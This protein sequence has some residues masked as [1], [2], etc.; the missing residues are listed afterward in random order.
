MA[1]KN[2]YNRANYPAKTIVCSCGKTA[3]FCSNKNYPFGKKSKAIISKFYR[4]LTCKKITFQ[5]KEE[6]FKRY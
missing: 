5:A 3:K 6:K 4:C 2:K 1:Y